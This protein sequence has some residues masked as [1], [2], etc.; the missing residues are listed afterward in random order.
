MSV[1][2]P[3]ERRGITRAP[4]R[5]TAGG[6]GFPSVSV[7]IP[8]LSGN[9]QRVTASL[10]RQTLRGF[11]L[12]IV[13]GTR[14]AARARNIG[15]A[16]SSGALL[17]FIDDDAYFGHARVMERLFSSLLS[18]PRIGVVGPSKVLPPHATRLQRRIAAE[19]PRWVH[20]ILDMDTVSDPPLDHYGFSGISTTCCLIRRAVFEQ[21]G[22]FD[23]RMRTGEDTELFYRIR[24]AGYRFV[25]PRRSWVCHDPPRSVVQLLRKGFEYGIGHALE[26]RKTPERR[27]AILPLDRWR[28][29]LVV[30]FAP[31]FFLPSLFVNVYPQS[32]PRLRIGF[33]PLKAASTYATFYGYVWGWIARDR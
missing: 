33:A 7:I 17:L 20:P 12:R 10:E 22:G 26:A 30:A 32:V 29:W 5:E 23:E 16:T 4:T 11:E 21:I 13:T 8:S 28:G 27:M 18:D 14:P 6:D 24:K 19:V 2:E 25:M 1:Q 3:Y 15:A 31:V 9:V